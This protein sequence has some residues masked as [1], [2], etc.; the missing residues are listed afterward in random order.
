MNADR[1]VIFHKAIGRL[2]KLNCK[3]NTDNVAYAAR[4]ELG[5]LDGRRGS[6]NN[7]NDGRWQ[8]YLGDDIDIE[9]DFNEATY[10]SKITMG[11]AQLTRYA[12]LFPKQIDVMSSQDGINYTLIKT[13]ENTKF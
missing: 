4:G 6:K 8:A 1:K 12:I 2:Y 13:A 9:L 11:F 7:F 10:I 5:L 3:W